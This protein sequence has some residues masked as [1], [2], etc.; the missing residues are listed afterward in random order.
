MDLVCGEG[1]MRGLVEE[2]V[3]VVVVVVVG[4][5]CGGSGSGYGGGS[6]CNVG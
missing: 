6:N 1:S 4:G 5:K 3:N 2:K